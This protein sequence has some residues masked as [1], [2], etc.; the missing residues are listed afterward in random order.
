MRGP[1]VSRA[2]MV[3][4]PWLARMHIKPEQGVF[5]QMDDPHTL[6]CTCAA[7]FHSCGAE[8]SLQAPQELSMTSNRR[9]SHV[10]LT[11]CLSGRL[12]DP[13][14]AWLLQINMTCMSVISGR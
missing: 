3:D 9:S 11:L 5:G 7:T 12:H 13:C 6:Q 2:G 1:A 4:K 8:A 10:L 14:S